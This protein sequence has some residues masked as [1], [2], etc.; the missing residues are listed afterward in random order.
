MVELADNNPAI[1]SLIDR[2]DLIDQY[3]ND[4]KKADPKL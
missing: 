4:I 3:G 1:Y 2:Y